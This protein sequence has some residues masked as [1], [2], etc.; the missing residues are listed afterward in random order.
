M[1]PADGTAA[2]SGR[3]RGYGVVR[4]LGWGVGD[5]AVSSLNNFALGIVVGRSL[6]SVGFGA[7]S[8]AYVTYT[9][10]LSA[11]RGLATDPLLVRFSGPPTA[12][13]RRAVASATATAMLGGAVAGVFLILIGLLLP[14][15][16]RGSFLA[17]GVVLPGLLLQDSLRF[18]FFSAGQT[19]RALVNDLFWGL[20]LVSSLAGLVVTGR[21]SAAACVL[22]FGLTGHAAALLGLAQCR[23]LPRLGLVRRWV[24][25]HRELGGRYLVGNVSI[26]GARQLRMLVLGAV[27]GLAAVGD[28]R[29]A[30]IL[31]GPFLVILLGASQVAVPEAA[32]VLRQA[33]RRLT[34]FCFVLGAALATAAAAWAA[35]MLLLLPAGVGEL[36]LG[37][38]WIPAAALLP[39]IAFAMVAGGFEV[40][41]ATGVRSL[42]AARRTL[43][44]Q[45]VNGVLYVVGG[46]VGAYVDGA[47]GSAWGVA[48]ATV[49]GTCVWWVQLRRALSDHLAASSVLPM[50]RLDS[51]TT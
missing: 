49:I 29:A 51:V 13:W 20:L 14:T 19:S 5:Q 34:R 15:G 38:M 21:A 28:T 32:Q 47:G 22:A 37:Q 9:F 18:A 26:A 44:V 33:P 1:A 43:K 25:D 46:A 42:G 17:L 2:A 3:G 24:T 4:R 27:A 35:V 7:F 45:L 6:G 8:L 11:S 39:P 48:L 10:I 23:V 50:N 12:E 36:L 31:M 40:A 30:E 16:V 41:A